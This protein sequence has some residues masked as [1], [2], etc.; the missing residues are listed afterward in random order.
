MN[1]QGAEAPAEILM[2]LARDLLVAEEQ[3]LML[4]ERRAQLRERR[5]QTYGEMNGLDLGAQRA[6]HPLHLDLRAALMSA[7]LLISSTM[8]SR[9]RGRRG[10]SRRRRVRCTRAR[11]S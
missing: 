11:A 3:H 2:L 1:L 8:Q 5:P 9:E 10:N 7:L 4:E 6:S